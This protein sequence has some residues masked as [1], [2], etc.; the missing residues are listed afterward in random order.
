[1]KMQ[2]MNL[3]ISFFIISR[4]NY[5][6]KNLLKYKFEDHNDLLN[7]NNSPALLQVTGN[8]NNIGIIKRVN[9]EVYDI[10]GFKKEDLLGQS[11]SMI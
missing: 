1:M 11:L 2:Q 6:K 4:A 7:E 3:S 9:N 5:I 10:T 8:F